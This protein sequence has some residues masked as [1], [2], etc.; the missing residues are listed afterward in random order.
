[1]KKNSSAAPSASFSG[2]R[3][4]GGRTLCGAIRI[5]SVGRAMVMPTPCPA[6]HSRARLAGSC[7]WTSQ[8][9]RPAP[10]LDTSTAG[11]MARAT[12]SAV[13]FRLNS[14]GVRVRRKIRAAASAASPAV[15]AVSSV[16]AIQDQPTAWAIATLAARLTPTAAI[17]ARPFMNNSAQTRKALA[18]QSQGTPEV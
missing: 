5:S 2:T 14:R 12:S 9:T 18:I 13:C 6:N 10:T 3:R 16:A 15:S 11:A 7:M 17:R 1:V 8:K 4:V